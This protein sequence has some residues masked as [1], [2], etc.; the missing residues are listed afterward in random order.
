M[1]VTINAD[2]RE[3]TI[4]TASDNNLSPAELAAQTLQTWQMVRDV[5][6][7]PPVGFANGTTTTVSQGP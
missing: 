5:T 1:R 7:K 3:V 4:E 6:D 2:G